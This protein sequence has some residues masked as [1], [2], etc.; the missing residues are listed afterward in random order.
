[1]SLPVLATPRFIPPLRPNIVP[2]PRL[3]ERLN[4]GLHRRLTRITA[5][6]RFLTYLVAAL[7]TVAGQIGEGLLG[8]LVNWA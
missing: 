6:T 3:A 7:R 4:K 1:M 5:S 8:A 2:R